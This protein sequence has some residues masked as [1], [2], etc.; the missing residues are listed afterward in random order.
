MKTLLEITKEHLAQYHLNVQGGEGFSGLLEITAKI[1]NKIDRRLT[2]DP[3]LK[4]LAA[5]FAQTTEKGMS[6]P[7]NR[8][9][10]LFMAFVHAVIDWEECNEKFYAQLRSQEQVQENKN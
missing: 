4:Q 3:A 1:N 10:L 8:T 9:M 2:N 7:G 6:M 5:H